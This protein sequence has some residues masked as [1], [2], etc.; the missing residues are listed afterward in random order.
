MKDY[1]KALKH[2]KLSILKIYFIKG[3]LFKMTASQNVTQMQFSASV[4]P[5]PDVLHCPWSYYITLNLYL[6]DP[7][8]LH[9]TW[10]YCITLNLNLFNNN[11]PTLYL[12]RYTVLHRIWSY[13]ITLN[14]ILYNHNLP[15]P[16]VLQWTWSYCITM[17][18]ILLLQWTWS[19]CIILYL[20]YRY[21]IDE[22]RHHRTVPPLP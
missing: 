17:N 13:Y 2:Q 6:P 22:A 8:V 9:W 19:Y 7:T 18:L 3:T 5:S 1:L 12:I 10:S 20:I 14:L 21:V 4:H 15:D 16:T 11:E